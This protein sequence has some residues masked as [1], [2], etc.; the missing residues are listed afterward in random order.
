MQ[1]LGLPFKCVTTLLLLLLL[2][3]Q[4]THHQDGPHLWEN[5]GKMV[6]LDKL[7]PKL[8]ANGDRVLIFS[9]MCVVVVW[10]VEYINTTHNT[11]HRTRLLDILEDYMRLKGY[12][13]CR[14]DGN[15]KG[16]DRDQFMDDY[17]APGGC[18]CCCL[19]SL[20]ST[21]HTLHHTSLPPF[22]HQAPFFSLMDAPPPHTGSSKF[23]FLLST[24]AGGLGINLATANIVILY[25][26]DW[27]P[28]MDLQVCSFI[29]LLF[30]YLLYASHTLHLPH[31]Y[32]ITHAHINH[33]THTHLYHRTL[34]YSW[35]S[36]THHHHTS[37]PPQPTPTH[38]PKIAHTALAKQRK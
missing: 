5:A 28:Q 38:R 22:T 14:I 8:K 37:T 12:E 29:P 21:Y 36:H 30:L 7:L 1:S 11:T 2:L 25:D 23:V 19:S 15:T 6:L 17:N 35:L 20:S 16:E 9:Q 3:I 31:V 34:S 26:S 24:R 27:N 4:I 33:H 18:C 10:S 13:Y 32:S